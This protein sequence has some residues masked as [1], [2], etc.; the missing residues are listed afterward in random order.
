MDENHGSEGGRARKEKLTPEQRKSIA[1]AA[2]KA[3]W[4]K[5]KKAKEVA[6]AAPVPPVDPPA[7]V[8]PEPAP[9]PALTRRRQSTVPMPK[10]FKGASSY[11]EKRLA[12]AIKQ[13]AEYMGRVAALNAEIPSLVSVIRAL[14]GNPMID[15]ASM[16]SYP[17][18]DGSTY[19]VMTPVPMQP[20][21]DPALPPSIDPALFRTNGAPVPGTMP[22][23]GPLI[24]NTAMG[25]AADLDYVP[26]EDQPRRPSG[27]GEWR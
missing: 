11:A 20:G 22:A 8:A 15:P 7:P 27:D 19:P 18:Q 17:L 23:P 24:P 10:A 2:S 6:A 5:A 25:G 13:R 9:R 16:Q 3:R 4:D 14:G 21:G 26:T 1:A 12:E